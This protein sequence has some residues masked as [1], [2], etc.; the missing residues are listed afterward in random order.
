MSTNKTENLNLHSWD[1]EDPVKRTEFNENFTALDAAWGDLETAKAVLAAGS[2]TGDGAAS[3]TISLGFTPKAVLV[4]TAYGVTFISGGSPSVCGGLAVTGHP[5]TY[6]LSGTTYTP[7]SI[8][9]GGF[10]VGQAGTGTSNT[11]N[12]NNSNI[13][14]HYIALA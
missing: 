13:T 6:T 3:R 14:Y 5:V 2:Y 11:S 12:T 7:V 1:A 10:A 9:D 8:V 4:M